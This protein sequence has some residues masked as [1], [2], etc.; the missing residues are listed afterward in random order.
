MR[1]CFIINTFSGKKGKHGNRYET[2]VQFVEAQGL[3]AVVRVTEYAGHARELARWAIASSFDRVVSVGG[4]GTMNEV[5]SEL[6]NS[7]VVF[8][9]VPLGSGNGLGRDLGISLEFRKALAGVVTGSVREID[10][11]C[12]NGVSFFNVMGLGFDAEVGR[13]FN[14]SKQRGFLS[15]AKLTLSSFR[16]YKKLRCRIETEGQ[17]LEREIF[18]LAI[19]NSTQYGNDAYIAPQALLDDGLLDLVC[20]E[21]KSFWRILGLGL[22]M[23]KRTLDRS[24]MVQLW[25][26][27]SFQISLDE[28]V[29][30]HTDGEIHQM[31]KELKVEVQPR[32]LKIL[33]PEEALKTE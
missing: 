8:G 22:R 29:T 30:L 28:D 4:D 7:G 32:S 13:R 20:I 14:E 26:G 16:S 24:P 1:Y 19:A 6:L 9:L 31:G 18:I 3:D 15:Y 25:K 21:T 5:A 10:T 27:R 33:V 23:F 2:V 17:T 11:G 12:V